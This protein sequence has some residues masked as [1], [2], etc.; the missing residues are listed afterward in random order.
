[1]LPMPLRVLIKVGIPEQC[2]DYEV[3]LEKKLEEILQTEGD[4]AVRN[5]L[6]GESIAL[7]VLALRRIFWF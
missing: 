1:M 3:C 5:Y 6:I 4:R 7:L 2:F